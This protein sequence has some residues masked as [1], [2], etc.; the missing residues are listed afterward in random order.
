MSRRH[1][2]SPLSVLR[3]FDMPTPDS[4]P[5]PPSNDVESLTLVACMKLTREFRIEKVSTAISNCVQLRATW[6]V[7]AGEEHHYQSTWGGGVR[8][9]QDFLI[10]VLGNIK[11]DVEHERSRVLPFPA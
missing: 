11:I 5:P 6:V 4:K 10:D 9:M 1:D 2:E 3:N 8:S 7:G